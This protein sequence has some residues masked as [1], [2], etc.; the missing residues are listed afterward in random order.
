MRLTIPLLLISVATAAAFEF[1][2]RRSISS[3]IGLPDQIVPADLDDDG[4]LDLV[5]RTGMAP[6][7][8][9]Y[10]NNGKGS[11]GQSA[12]WEAAGGD[13]IRGIADFDSDGTPDLLLSNEDAS[14]RILY[15]NGLAGYGARETALGNF[16][17]HALTALVADVDVSGKPDVILFDRVIIDPGRDQALEVVLGG[18]DFVS[19]SDENLRWGD[20]NGDDLPDALVTQD[21]NV[22]AAL[23]EGGGQFAALLPLPWESSVESP[24]IIEDV[25]VVR[26]SR[27]PSGRGFIVLVRNSNDDAQRLALLTDGSGGLMVTHSLPFTSST[28]TSGRWCSGFTTTPGKPLIA[29]LFDATALPFPQDYILTSN[30]GSAVEIDIAF[31]RSGPSLVTK[32]RLNFQQG[33]DPVVQ[34]DL[35]DDGIDDL[36]TSSWRNGD[37]HGGQLRFYAGKRGGAFTKLAVSITGPATDDTAKHVTDFDGDGDKDL[38]GLGYSIADNS[39]EVVLWTNLGAGAFSRGKLVTGLHHAQL[40]SI[41]DRNGDSRP[42]LLLAHVAWDK[43]KAAGERVLQLVLSGKGSKRRTQEIFRETGGVPWDQ[44]R[45]GDWDDDGVD[46]LLLWE[47]ALEDHHEVYPVRWLK[48][49]P[50][51]SFDV[52]LPL[53][54][55]FY[56][57]LQDM[58]GDGDL[59]L[60]PSRNAFNRPSVQDGWRENVGTG[61]PIFHEFPEIAGLGGDEVILSAEADLNGDGRIDLLAVSQSELQHFY[62]PVLLGAGVTFAAQ[63]SLP[64]GTPWFHNMDGDGDLDI[65]LATRTPGFVGTQGLALLENTGGM[66]YAAPVTI[67]VPTY[68]DWTPVL[69]GD[70]SGDGKPDVIASTLWRRPRIEWFKAE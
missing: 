11:F 3:Y 57:T 23:N 21:A 40:I 41:A 2:T 56:E 28:E 38:L 66:N 22:L 24:G 25:R 35:N 52:P 33:A 6:A 50:G 27:L 65:L 58:D 32:T 68:A 19:G 18:A 13:G 54:R 62:R 30:K 8:L 14:L 63:P 39:A 59:D 49:R 36:V 48:G 51:N 1:E 67:Q 10:K 12:L 45:A 43:K 7:V 61:Q 46:D 42:D 70:L 26:D 5:A 9:I 20:I 4:D 53:G 34:A 47:T 15:G 16:P 37:T 44:V 17:E 31:R 60:V 64:S 69:A 55:G 29:S